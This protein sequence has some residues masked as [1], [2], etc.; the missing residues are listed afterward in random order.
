MSKFDAVYFHFFRNGAS[1]AMNVNGSVTAVNFDITAPAGDKDKTFI[2]RINVLIQDTGVRPDWFGGTGVGAAL[3][4]GLR[5]VVLDKD[6]NELLDWVDG[7][8]IK[9]NGEWVFL[10]GVDSPIYSPLGA[11]DDEVS[12]R[13]TLERGLGPPGYELEPGQ[14]FRVI[15]QDNL[16][17]ITSFRMF[18]QGTR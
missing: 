10:A 14:T 11:G 4:N 18:A 13:W 3:S 5:I 17:G 12:V 1:E 2:K 15:V 6:G 16:S 8:T 9:D 7:A